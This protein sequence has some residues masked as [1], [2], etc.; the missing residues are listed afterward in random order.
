MLYL[1]FLKQEIYNHQEEHNAGIQLLKHA[2]KEEYGIERFPKMDRGVHGKPY[3]ME[4]QCYFNI[5]HTKGIVACA[6][7]ET[8]LG[9]DVE[10]VREVSKSMERRVLSEEEREWLSTQ[11][12]EEAFIRLWTLKESYIKATGEGLTME[13]S[14]I[15]FQFSN[16]EKEKRIRCNQKGYSFYQQKV[17]G[18]AYL[19]I[20]VKAIEIPEEMKKLNIIF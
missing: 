4:E 15:S 16:K 14:K 5:S 1:T 20:C 10:R 2:I 18:N 6:L 13:L 12:R 9:I 11:K 7:G 3:F 8:E 19:A 17:G